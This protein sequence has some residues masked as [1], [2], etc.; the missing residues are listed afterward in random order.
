M[1]LLFCIL[2]DGA[3]AQAGNPPTQNFLDVPLINYTLS[4]IDLYVRGP[5]GNGHADI[6]LCSRSVPL[7]EQ[8]VRYKGEVFMAVP[9]A[10]GKDAARGE[11]LYNCLMQAQARYGSG[12][13]ALIDVSLFTPV[14]CVDDIARLVETYT[15]SGADIV[16]TVTKARCHPAS[17][18]WMEKKGGYEP[19]IASGAAQPEVFDIV[20]S[21]CAYRCEWLLKSTS[22]KKT[23]CAAAP[24][25]DTGILQIGGEADK[26]VLQAIALGLYQREEYA[27]V[28][29]HIKD[30]FD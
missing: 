10:A 5:L 2:D 1:N 12:Y 11:L 19:V 13:D 17:G 4:A 23:R 21:L 16:R 15:Q 24:V 22:R 6:V 30:C 9:P 18:Q 29:G 27:A 28:R 3:C 14:R 8:C 20:Q 7:V 25:L 26:E